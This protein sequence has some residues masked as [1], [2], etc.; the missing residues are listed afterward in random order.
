[1]QVCPEEQQVASLARREFL[2]RLTVAAGVAASA[3]RV[4]GASE[5]APA[6][7]AAAGTSVVSNDQWTA[8][9]EQFNLSPEYVH[10]SALLI[11]SHPTPVR[12][13]I[14]EYRRE[15]DEHPVL[16][17]EQH[18]RERQRAARAAAARYLGT[19]ADQIAL[20]DSTTMGVGLMY[21]GLRLRP[22]DEILT[23]DQD[24]YVTHEAVRQAAVRHGAK[25][26]QISLY[27]DL[28]DVSEEQL[29]G[30]IR[31]A[32]GA[33]TR[34]VALTWVHSSTGLKLPLAEI[35]NAIAAV[36][37]TRDDADR[38]LLAIDGV[39]G[40]GIEDV[41]IGRLGLDFFAA[42]C[43]K[44]LFGPRGTGILWG[45]ARGWAACLPLIPSFTD[46]GTWSAWLAGDEQPEGPV[47]A[48]RMQP[49]GFKAFEH[50]WA[51][52]AAFEMHQELGKAAVQQRTHGLARQLKEG[53][54]A[55]A[56]VELVTPMSESLSSGIVSFDVNGLEPRQAVRRLREDQVIASVTPYAV[57]HVRLTPSI[58]NTPE[59]VD[60]TLE[61]IRGLG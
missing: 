59:D 20:T 26:R 44:W 50:Q 49:G 24:Y 51:L 2:S 12:E 42:G 11:V 18:N 3:C 38:V 52:P 60:R 61:A 56:H 5:T 55:M 27:E 31:D 36:N 7:T 39:H 46:D 29:V 9:R 33:R 22:D 48:S 14:D 10:M 53:L 41:E 8:F 58:R 1:V 6:R 28:A 47:T 30:T 25:V 57:R 45:S 37:K 17:L 4:N 13:A 54:Q 15:I 43:H 23:T 19:D 40:F 35:A 21:N 34:V 32:I 16:T